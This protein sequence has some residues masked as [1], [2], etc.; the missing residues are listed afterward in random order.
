VYCSLY[1][2]PPPAAMTTNCLPVFFP[3]E[4]KKGESCTPDVT[5]L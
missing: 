2:L 1:L 3:S 5:R 4:S